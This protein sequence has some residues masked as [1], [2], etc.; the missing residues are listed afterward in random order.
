MVKITQKNLIEQLGSLKEIKPRQEWASLLKSEILNPKLKTNYNVQNYK[1]SKP[2]SDFV[3]RIS[4]FFFGLKIQKRLA[5]SFATLAFI[6]VGLIGFA[7][8][9]MPGDLLFPVRKIAEK[10]EAALTGQTGIKQNVVTLNNRINDLA[11]AAKEGKKDNIP[12]AISEINTNALELAKSLKD[13]PAEDPNTLK[14]I[15]ISLKVLASVPGA[16]L[17]ASPDVKDLYQAVVEGQIADLEKSTL[18]ETQQETLNEIKDLYDQEEYV[19]ALEKIL[20][21]NNN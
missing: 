16:D 4:D 20:L 19:D 18:T 7:Q 13:N 11:K 2:V 14:E 17:S 12:S 9:T 15:A 21:I 1:I 6:F 10:S 5:Y 3:L 8:Y